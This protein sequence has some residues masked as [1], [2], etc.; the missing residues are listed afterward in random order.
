MTMILALGM[1]LGMAAYLPRVTAAESERAQKWQGSIPLTFTSGANYD[2]HGTSVDLNDDLGWGFGFGYNVSEHFLVGSNFT[3]ISA[4]YQATIA[5]YD[6][7]GN[8]TGTSFDVS[9]SLDATNWQLFGQYNILKGRITPF[10][11][12]SFGWSWIDSNIPSGF[13][14]TGCWWDPWYG[15]ICNTYQPTY[16]AT[17]FAYGAAAGVHAEL[18]ERFYLEGSYNYLWV[19][20]SNAGTQG[21]DG[22]RLNVGWMF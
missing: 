1:T 2:E 11:Q 18:G 20:F 19:D 21:F 7:S 3:W 12:A 6:N 4:S 9:G 5:D 17:P 14:Q 8:P 22:F 16:E 10:L 13:P 15:Y